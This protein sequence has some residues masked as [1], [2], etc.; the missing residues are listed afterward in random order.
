M[1]LI[2]SRATGEG[3]QENNR[4]PSSYHR[5]HLHRHSLGITNAIHPALAKMKWKLELLSGLRAQNK[6][7]SKLTCSRKRYEIA[8]LADRAITDQHTGK[9][10]FSRRKISGGYRVLL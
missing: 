5:L 2:I 4:V 1:I 9:H 7:Q 3:A 8:F 10:L 6:N